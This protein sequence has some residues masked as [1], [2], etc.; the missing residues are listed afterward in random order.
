[1]FL[2]SWLLEFNEIKKES[3]TPDSLYTDMKEVVRKDRDRKREV[4]LHSSDY[5]PELTKCEIS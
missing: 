2:L 4:G 5:Y 1:M 3:Y